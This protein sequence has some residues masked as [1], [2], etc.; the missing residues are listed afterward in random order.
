MNVVEMRNIYKYFG[1]FCANKDVNFSLEE[2]E[3]HALLGENGAG[4]STLMNVLYGMYNSAEGQIFING[5]EVSIKSPND[6][7]EQGVGMV[8]QHFMLIPQLTVTQNVFMGMKEAGLVYNMK[9]LNKRVT[10]M[11]EKF[12]FNVDDPTSYIW[13]LPVGVQQKVE[14]IKVLMRNA[15]ILILDEPTAVLTPQE[16]KELFKSLKTLVAQGYSII[17]ITHHMNEVLDYCDRVTVMRLGEVIGTVN[18]KDT[19][20]DELANM[21]VGRKINLNRKVEPQEQ[22]EEMIEVQNLHV[23]NDKGLEAVKGVSFKVHAGEIVGIAGVDGNGQLELAEAIVGGRK[24][25]EGDVLFDNDSVTKKDVRY[26]LDKGMAHIPDD[27]QKKGLIMQMAIKDNFVISNERTDVYKSGLFM[28]RKK[29]NKKADELVKEFDVR[30]A[31]SNYQAGSLSGGN[32][33][34]VILARE[35]DRKPKIMI[36]IQPTRGLDIGAI[37]FVRA[38][39]IEERAR[40]TAVLLIS[41]DLDEILSLSDRIM[42]MHGGEFMGEVTYDEPIENIGLMMAGRK[43]ESKKSVEATDERREG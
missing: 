28:D 4:K 39:L 17:L 20:A 21:M 38:K 30:P 31:D 19:S 22:G 35:V 12:G 26:R 42:I 33:Q 6:A 29:I 5:K 3:I 15:K 13:Q 11:S 16:V 37:E 23:K 34:K 25:E 10:D 40:Q 41:T 24:I 9:A 7:I 43:G 18:V 36:A 2:G 32:Q 1:S 14:I 27:R 8:H